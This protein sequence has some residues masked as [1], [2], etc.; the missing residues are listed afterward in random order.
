[1]HR[2]QWPKPQPLNF[3]FSNGESSDCRIENDHSPATP[4]VSCNFCPQNLISVADNLTLA[5]F[6]KRAVIDFG[7]SL[8]VGMPCTRYLRL[9][10]PRN[11]SIKVQC[12]R[13][14]TSDEFALHWLSTS[15]DV[16]E[17]LSDPENEALIDP[18]SPVTSLV[19]TPSF[20]LAHHAECLLRIVWTPKPQPFQS[21]L[22]AKVTS[23]HAA[24]SNL[25]HNLQFTLGGGSLIVEANI[26]ASTIK[27]PIPRRSRASWALCEENQKRQ[28]RASSS[29]LRILAAHLANKEKRLSQSLDR[30]NL[31]ASLL[32]E[33]EFQTPKR[34]ISTTTDLNLI[35]EEEPATAFIS[36]ALL[37]PVVK[38]GFNVL[39]TANKTPSTK[40][41]DNIFGWDASAAL[42]EANELGFT[43]WLNHLFTY[44]HATRSSISKSS[45]QDDPK[46]ALLDLLQ[47]PN[48]SAPGHRIER[49]IDS[50]KLVVNKDL[51]F[52]ADKGLQL[53]T[54]ELFTSHYSPIW[55][56]PCVEV[57]YKFVNFSE[58]QLKLPPKAT[59]MT[60]RVY[61][62]LF[63]DVSPLKT[64]SSQDSGKHLSKTWQ[65]QEHYNRQVVKRCLTL[66]WLLDQAKL[67]K[68]RRFDPCLFNLSA[69]AK[70][71]AAVCLTLGRNYLTRESNLPRSL[72][73][74]GANLSVSQT[75]L[76]EFDFTVTNLAVDLRDGLR[77][78]KLADLLLVDSAS[79]FQSHNGSLISLVR[80]PAISRLQKI[81]NVRLALSAFE[82]IV[83][84]KH[85]CTAAGKPISERDI[86]DGHRSKTL[87]LLWFILLRFQ[88]TALLN[89]P[90]LRGE[91]SRLID[92]TPITS[93]N[94][95]LLMSIRREADILLTNSSTFG[96]KTHDPLVE[97]ENNQRTLFLWV[98][99]VMS[100]GGYSNVNVEN[101][102][103]SFG[104][105]RIFCYLLHYYLPILLPKR[106]VRIVTT[107]TIK[108]F[109][110]IPLNFLL[111]NNSFN[112]QLFQQRLSQLA[113][114]PSLI[115]IG[116]KQATASVSIENSSAVLS[117][118]IVL[119]TLAFLASWI[120]CAEEGVGR[121]RRTVRN[122]AARIIQVWWRRLRAINGSGF[123][124]VR[125][126]SRLL[127]TTP[128]ASI[129][130][131]PTSTITVG[132]DF[133]QSI[134][135]S[136][137]H[138]EEVNHHIVEDAT[139]RHDASNISPAASGGALFK[140]TIST[141]REESHSREPEVQSIVESTQ[142]MDC[143][144][145]ICDV[146]LGDSFIESALSEGRTRIQSTPLVSGHATPD[147]SGRSSQSESTV[148]KNDTSISSFSFTE[149]TVPAEFSFNGKSDSSKE[150]I[151]SV[152]NENRIID[153]LEMTA[154]SV[155]ASF[156][157]R[158]AIDYS[159]ESV[160]NNA[161]DIDE[162]EKK[163]NAAIR[164]QRS[165]RAW[166]LE[167][168]RKAFVVEVQS[169]VKSFL[170]KKVIEKRQAANTQRRRLAALVIQNAWRAYLTRKRFLQIREKVI[171]LQAFWRQVLVRRA[172]A[173]RIEEERCVVII[174]RWW[175]SI[176][177]RR[178]FLLQRH[179]AI[180][181]QS[182]WRST[183]SERRRQKLLLELQIATQ[184]SIVIQ[185][186]VRAFLSR[187][188]QVT[189]A[190]ACKI[191]HWWRM[192]LLRKRIDA[193]V[194]KSRELM[195]YRENNA[196]VTIQRTWRLFKQRK[197][198]N[199]R[200]IFQRTNAARIIQRAW[201]IYCQRRKVEKEE[202]AVILIQ[203]NWR[204]SR[205]RLWLYHRRNAALII[206]A[207]WRGYKARS[208]VAKET[209]ACATAL[210]KRLSEANKQA[211][212]QPH[213]C[214]GARAQRA[215]ANL[216]RY[217]SVTSVLDALGH[218]EIA[219]RL[220]HEVCTWL[221]TVPSSSTPCGHNEY[222]P[223]ALLRLLHLCN[224]SVADEEVALAAVSVMLN[225]VNNVDYRRLDSS[226]F[227]NIWWQ[228]HECSLAEFEGTTNCGDSINS[229]SIVEFLF[230]CLQ[231]LSRGRIG[232]GSV[233]LFA[234]TAALLSKLCAALRP[235]FE[236]PPH[237]VHQIEVL[238][239]SVRRLWSATL[240]RNPVR[241]EVT[242]LIRNY[243]VTSSRREFLLRRVDLELN[244]E[245]L[246]S[247]P[248]IDPLVAC[249]LLMLTLHEHQFRQRQY[250]HHQQSV[251]PGSPF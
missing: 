7:D 159:P 214:L 64:K 95:T 229:K 52:K 73:N 120:V 19:T 119:T 161:N 12:K 53:R 174:Q 3:Y 172:L 63:A 87:S 196:A 191:Q 198:L 43:R 104:D 152:F 107:Q 26:V 226:T 243:K 155:L 45:H 39:F 127:F 60:K 11:S 125:L 129:E 115:N 111:R 245:R 23:K 207:T 180:F 16:L 192:C 249:E 21:L 106:L 233:R 179:S 178:V 96:V 157:N 223:H 188:R 84:Q 224:R 74:F 133:I 68:I 164:I 239:P 40:F 44:G 222:L 116:T 194:T 41:P 85:L 54:V 42:S 160:A 170:A 199:E 168:R 82:K 122:H 218:L 204:A 121:L 88:V 156:A 190:A 37:S 235:D 38:Q 97:M 5:P 219:T 27:Q 99:A 244:L 69:P 56:T 22:D 79:I 171:V 158:S 91:I 102:D 55:L 225:L 89:L 6:S 77:L 151:K 186:Y 4:T 200:S 9:R 247:K 153:D 220:S 83:G 246:P 237:F 166:L 195:A 240:S 62:Y 137:F 165:V 238:L 138:S 228:Q 184:A 34:A 103:Q 176:Q 142:Q 36:P 80:F 90:A 70:S 241:A 78:V 236:I 110:G 209:L 212:E 124:H 72:S 136:D 114:V 216:L 221:L 242:A 206:Q 217:T 148:Q 205:L 65:N 112:L 18:E 126:S 131:L 201:K 145:S 123:R 50:G 20:E 139:Q 32:E 227:H 154:I 211:K 113:D 66:I 203:R 67:R 210:R 181:I 234:R 189:A 13:Y 149:F 183:L 71:S 48:F 98:R 213:K 51:N 143:I 28:S 46:K 130:D 135:S 215:L 47:T 25:R 162:N 132:D 59:A 232:T 109:P 2:K 250:N 177:E 76:D 1:M 208:S 24:F 118:G 248:S 231:R 105:G 169:E 100:A 134:I 202:Q 93:A 101:L 81:H 57:L 185:R 144:P 251:R 187:R 49:E 173:Q 175:R 35:L 86:V 167:R 197:E 17:N 8:T 141:D 182:W 146:T 147:K 14:P 15:Q 193:A 128:D 230:I 30:L 10:N 58:G 150:S 31:E 163:H 140:F 92:S 75:P 117:P 33:A 108:S 61:R 94:R 29:G